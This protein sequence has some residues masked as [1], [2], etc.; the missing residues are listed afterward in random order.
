MSRGPA[1]ATAAGLVLVISTAWGGRVLEGRRA[2]L[3]SDAAVQR[4][5]AVEATLT[6]RI[7]AESRCPFCVSESRGYAR[8]E[9]IAKDAESRGDDLVAFGA[10]RAMRTASL[11]N[12]GDRRARAETELARLGHK[13]DAARTTGGAP[14]AAAAED[15]LREVLSED[16]A[17]KSMTFLLLAAG[18]IGFLAGAIRFAR[19]GRRVPEL[20]IAGAGAIVAA[21]GVLYF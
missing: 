21:L 4:G 6:A 8:L 20:L 2:M 15:K 13:L 12:D 1:I 5:D 16:D 17:P 10:F 18:A 11:G 7:A 3:D 14:T 9:G 19:T